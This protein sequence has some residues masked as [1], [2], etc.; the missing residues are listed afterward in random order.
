VQGV[1]RLELVSVVNLR[2][3]TKDCCCRKCTESGRVQHFESCWRSSARSVYKVSEGVRVDKL[4]RDSSFGISLRRAQRVYID[5]GVSGSLK[6][7]F[8]ERVV[9]KA[10]GHF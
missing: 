7:G 10:L 3:R 5:E 8:R 9:V 6:N 1:R 4:K 2:E